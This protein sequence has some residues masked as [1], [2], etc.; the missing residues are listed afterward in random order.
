MTKPLVSAAA[1]ALG[2][3]GGQANTP[4]QNAARARN[5]R[6]AGRPRRVCTTCLQPVVG[7]GVHKD[8]TLDEVCIGRDWRWQKPSERP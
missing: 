2:R 1:Q 8:R 3:L 7:G 6:L 5:A 4:A